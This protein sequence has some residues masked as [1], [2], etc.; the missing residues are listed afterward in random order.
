MTESLPETPYCALLFAN[1]KINSYTSEISYSL[2][3]YKKT[4]RIQ[5]M[6]V[7]NVASNI[8]CCPAGRF[9]AT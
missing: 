3:N 6:K 5:N 8:P 2:L 4:K 9:S 1:L 7:V